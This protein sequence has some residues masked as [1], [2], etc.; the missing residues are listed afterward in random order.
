[1]SCTSFPSILSMVYLRGCYIRPSFSVSS[2]RKTPASGLDSEL[3]CISACNPALWNRSTDSI[4]LQ[5][6]CIGSLTFFRQT[7]LHH[8]PHWW[9]SSSR[10]HFSQYQSLETTQTSQRC[11]SMNLEKDHCKLSRHFGPHDHL[12]APWVALRLATHEGSCH[13]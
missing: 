11:S 12:M 4:W 1:M 3:Q 8:S 5:T 6:S 2:G 7:K 13:C 10:W 9:S